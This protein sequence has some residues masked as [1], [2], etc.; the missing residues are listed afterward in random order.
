ML[1]W[2]PPVGPDDGGNKSSW[3]KHWDPVT[4]ESV[5]VL[6]GGNWKSSHETFVSLKMETR[7]REGPTTMSDSFSVKWS[8]WRL[9]PSVSC[10]CKP[11]WWKS[12]ALID[13]PTICALW[14]TNGWAAMMCSFASFFKGNISLDDPRIC[15]YVDVNTWWGW[16]TFTAVTG[17]I[18]VTFASRFWY[19]FSNS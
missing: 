10:L 13:E 19:C 14:L 5:I 2:C 7:S 6:P 16:C 11:C 4:E 1:L 9:P 18:A 17:L 3:H 15:G 12:E 8:A